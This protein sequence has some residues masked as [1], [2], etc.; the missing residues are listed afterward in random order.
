MDRGAWQV[1]VLPWSRKESHTTERLTQRQTPER[2]DFD[3][4][5]LIVAQILGRKK[6]K[7]FSR[8]KESTP[9][10]IRMVFEVWDLLSEAW[11][12]AVACVHFVLFHNDVAGDRW[13][14]TCF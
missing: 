12:A 13:P 14:V 2:P 7:S 11:E 9:E 3:L 4:L 10:F 8:L 6:G 1:T 5:F